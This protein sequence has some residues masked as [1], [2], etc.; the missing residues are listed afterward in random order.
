MSWDEKV[1]K[2]MEQRG[3]NQLQLANLSG[4]SPSSISRYLSS[5]QRPR[6]DV[7]I[8]IA[9]ALEV[10]TD[11]LLDEGESLDSAYTTISTAIARKGAELTPEEKNKLIALLLGS[12][13]NV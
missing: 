10:D 11:F 7:V 8:N 6:M 1:K 2:V 13:G 4:I 9:K 5:K 3:I 12:G